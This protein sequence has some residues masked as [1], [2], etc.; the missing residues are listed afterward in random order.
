[1]YHQ[2]KRTSKKYKRQPGKK[3]QATLELALSLICV[4]LLLLGALKVFIWVNSRMVMRQED[5]EDSRLRAGV[6]NSTIAAQTQVSLVINSDMRGTQEIWGLEEI[7]NN[8][9]ALSEEDR[10]VYYPEITQLTL[11]YDDG[12]EESINISTAGDVANFCS[13]TVQNL[14]VNPVIVQGA[15]ESK[16]PK[17]DIFGTT[18]PYISKENR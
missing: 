12:R 16:Y 6:V 18:P 5:Y 17:L 3:A 13:S 9:C 11:K 15:D 2:Q 14:T 1:M 10:E 7:K 8:F 4:L